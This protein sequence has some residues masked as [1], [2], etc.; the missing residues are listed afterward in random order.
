[1][2]KVNDIDLELQTNLDKL[3]KWANEWQLPRSYIIPNLT[4][5]RYVDQAMLNIG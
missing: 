3:C 2:I 5:F 4:C 1:M